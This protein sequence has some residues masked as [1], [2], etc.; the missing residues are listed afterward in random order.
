MS[1]DPSRPESDGAQFEFTEEGGRLLVRVPWEQAD[2]LRRNLIRA[3]VGATLHLDVARREA[4]IEPWTN[5]G[6]ER[7]GEILSGKTLQPAAAT[8]S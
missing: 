7:L 6:P 3:G 4:R 1:T 5:L 8:V 2:N